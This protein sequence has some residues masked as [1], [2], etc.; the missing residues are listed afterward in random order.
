M[1]PDVNGAL[2]CY[3]YHKTNQKQRHQ[4]NSLL[5]IPIWT[6][7]QKNTILI[8]LAAL[9]AQNAVCFIRATD[10]KAQKQ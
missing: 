10:Q 7:G 4:V 8:I 1:N 3:D 2:P 5:G 9:L 6:Y